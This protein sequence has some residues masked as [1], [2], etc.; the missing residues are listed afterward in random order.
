MPLY[1][2]IYVRAGRL[3]GCTFAALDAEKATRFAERWCEKLGELYT[4]K[5]VESRVPWVKQRRLPLCS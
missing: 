2:M 4:V 5:P 3:K 1:R